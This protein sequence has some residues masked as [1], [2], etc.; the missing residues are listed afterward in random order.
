MLQLL[1]EVPNIKMSLSKWQVIIKISIS[2][3]TK[4]LQHDMWKRKC[5]TMAWQWL[6]LLTSLS[7]SYN[8]IQ[9]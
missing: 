4:L 9:G 5:V 2:V 7:W 8:Y 1:W 3:A 6:R